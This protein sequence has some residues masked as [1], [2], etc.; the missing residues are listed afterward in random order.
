MVTLRNRSW[1]L[2]Q[3]EFD[4]PIPCRSASGT[5]CQVWRHPDRF[6]RLMKRRSSLKNATKEIL[7]FCWKHVLSVLSE[8]YSTF[9]IKHYISAEGSFKNPIFKEM[10]N[11]EKVLSFYCTLQY[12]DYYQ[13]F[14]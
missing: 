12:V 14:I 10:S 3:P 5:G 1:P 6:Q 13:L 8:T 4:Q 2:G 11:V 7:S 9:S